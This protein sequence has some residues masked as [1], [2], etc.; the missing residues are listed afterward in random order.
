[1]RTRLSATAITIAALLLAV[2]DSPVVGADASPVVIAAEDAE[3][4]EGR[5]RPCSQA[6][7]ERDAV[8]P[9]AL[10]SPR[11]AEQVGPDLARE[12]VHPSVTPSLTESAEVPETLDGRWSR[13]PRSP[14]AANAAATAFTGEVM[15]VVDPA[16]GRTAAY[17]PMEREWVRLKRAP[18]GFHEQSPAVWTGHE[19]VIVDGGEGESAGLAFNLAENRWREIAPPPFMEAQGSVWTGD[20]VVAASLDR[21]AGAYVPETDCWEPLPPVPGEH[22]LRD[23]H[24]TG[25]E[26]LA[27]TESEEPTPLAIARLGPSGEW[28]LTAD[29]PVTSYGS[30]ALWAGDRLL[31]FVPGGNEEQITWNAT[32]DPV[33]DEWRVLDVHCRVSARESVWTG[34]L[35][36]DGFNHGALD[37]ATGRCFRLPRSGRVDPSWHTRT[38]SWFSRAWTGTELVLWSGSLGAGVPPQNRGVTFT[39]SQAQGEETS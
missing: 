2:P 34:E 24:W 16:S 22:R 6:S 7:S 19:L 36:L 4:A 13:I 37:L 8:G 30:H 29:G 39:L 23:L 18:R 10:E 1:M 3:G 12:L 35:V 25:S 5:T 32:Y 9:N 14:L 20:R 31:F 33:G 26:I 11:R 38:R 15:I 27:V 28:V 21:I 17:D